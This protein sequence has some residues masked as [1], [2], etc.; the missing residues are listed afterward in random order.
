[1]TTS[2]AQSD[3]DER[4][5]WRGLL[6]LA[7]ANIGCQVVVVAINFVWNTIHPF[8]LGWARN[9]FR[10][11]AETTIDGQALAFAIAAAF[12]PCRRFAGLFATIAFSIVL[13]AIAWFPYAMRDLAADD[14]DGVLEWLPHIWFH[15]RS[16]F[17]FAIAQGLRFL[18]GWRLVLPSAAS[19]DPKSQFGIADLIEWTLSVGVFLGIAQLSG[20]LAP[21]SLPLSAV[22]FIEQALVSLPAALSVAARSRSRWMLFL[23]IGLALVARAADHVAFAY[24]FGNSPFFPRHWVVVLVDAMSYVTV[25]GINFVVIRRL[26]FQLTSPGKQAA[27]IKG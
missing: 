18:L 20:W 2:L 22:I 26:G 17:V 5:A 4:R 8:D 3:V 13:G 7:A 15:C 23:A 11:A 14:V 19:Q 27:P 16:L 24:W 21:E 25:V 12:I 1:M 6:W 9:V 10:A